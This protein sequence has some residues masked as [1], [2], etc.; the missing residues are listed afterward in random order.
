MKIRPMNTHYSAKLNL[1][2]SKSV[3]KIV[4]NPKYTGYAV[5]YVEM[6]NSFGKKLKL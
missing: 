4:I 5:I 2:I 6:L 1:N 3:Q